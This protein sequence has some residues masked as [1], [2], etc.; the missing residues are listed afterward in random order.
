MKFLFRKRPVL[1]AAL[2]ALA[3]LPPTQFA[4]CVGDG[5]HRELELLSADCCPADSEHV[6]RGDVEDDDGC[7]DHCIDTPVGSGGAAGISSTTTNPYTDNHASLDVVAVLPNPG[8]ASFVLKAVRGRD[9]PG[10]ALGRTD[11]TLRNSV[12]RL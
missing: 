12:R 5:G 8:L 4:L 1:L 2:L 3:T 7:A 6:E 9:G 11:A 10:H